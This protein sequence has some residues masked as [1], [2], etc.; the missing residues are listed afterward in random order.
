MGFDSFEHLWI[1]LYCSKRVNC[2]K[3]LSYLATAPATT[4]MAAQ[5]A[6]QMTIAA[7]CAPFSISSEPP[8]R[9]H[10]SVSHSKQNL[11]SKYRSLY[12]VN[13]HNK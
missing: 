6:E 2:N 4:R 13:M 1:E 3:N 5:R 8:A 7:M 11:K 10:S 9:K 12:E